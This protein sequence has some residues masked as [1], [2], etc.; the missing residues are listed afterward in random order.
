LW[1]PAYYNDAASAPKL[2]YLPRPIVTLDLPF[3]CSVDEHKIPLA[4]GTKSFGWSV[5]GL[6]ITVVGEFG[7]V[8][9]PT[10]G[11][12]YPISEADQ[13]D[14]VSTYATHLFTGSHTNKGEFFLFYDSSGGGTYRKFKNVRPLTFVPQLGDDKRVVYGYTATF[15]VE[16]PTIYTTAPG[17]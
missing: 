5:N 1:K 14:A 9:N 3:E 15:L 13:W 11:E 16:T 6:K 4:T 10:D 2:R 17:V 8:G 7:I 12:S